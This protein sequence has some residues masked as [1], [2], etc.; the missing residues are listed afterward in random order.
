MVDWNRKKSSKNASNKNSS[1]MVCSHQGCDE[2]IDV[3][4]K[5]KSPME[6]VKYCRRHGEWHH[7]SNEKAKWLKVEKNP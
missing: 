5:F 3:R 4:V 7:H 6:V 1:A 2:S